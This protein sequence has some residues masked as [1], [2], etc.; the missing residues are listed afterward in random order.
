[1]KSFSVYAKGSNLFLIEVKCY[2]KKIYEVMLKKFVKI[3]QVYVKENIVCDEK[4]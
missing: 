1:M 4:I 2:D 3:R